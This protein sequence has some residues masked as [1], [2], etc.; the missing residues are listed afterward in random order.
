MIGLLKTWIVAGWFASVTAVLAAGPASPAPEDTVY[1]FSTFREPEQDGLLFAYSLDGHHWARVPGRF[2]EPRVGGKVFRDPSICRGPD[3][4]WH[5]VWTSAWRGDRSF[6][7][8]RSRDLVHWEDQRFI[9]VMEHEPETVNVWAPELFYDAPRNRFIIVW[10]STI[11]GRFPD[12]LEPRTNNHRLYYTITRDFRQFAPT[13]LFWDP[14]YS[15]IDAQIV[16]TDPGYVL[17]HKDN[18][19]PERRLRVAFGSSPLGPW[20]D[21]WP[22]IT[23]PFTEGPSALKVGD[24]WII[25]YE[26]YRDGEYRALKSRDFRIFRNATREMTFPP[27]LKHGTAFRATRAD[28]ERLLQAGAA[29]GQP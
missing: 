22:P 2:M 29:A 26:A 9:P 21:I 4:I 23:E 6:G 8:A 18:T 28:L 19:R 25:Y 17:V 24:E 12:Y 14:G 1:L 15:V 20:R 27:G 7:Y 10:A 5:L 11:P 3:G 13:K 16:F